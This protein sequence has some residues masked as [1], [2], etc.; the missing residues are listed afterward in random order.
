MEP[1]PQSRPGPEG[2]EGVVERY[3]NAVR[4]QSAAVP[5]SYP[6]P[7]S[8]R[9]PGSPRTPLPWPGPGAPPL[10][11]AGL[12]RLSALLLGY[13]PRRV[14]TLTSAGLS[15]LTGTPSSGPV[16][17][18]VLPAWFT[19]RRSVPSGGAY[20]PGEIYLAWTG[21]AELP[22]G[23]YHYDHV[24][25]CLELL[26]SASPVAELDRL[27]GA[28]GTPANGARRSALLLACRPWKNSGKYR[29]FGYQLGT[30]DVGVLLGQ[31]LT[32]TPAATVHLAPD[33]R[34]AD[35]LLGLDGVVESV[36]AV[37]ELPTTATVEPDAPPDRTPPPDPVGLTN[38]RLALAD[39]DPSAVALHRAI[40][41]G[42]D[43]AV[44]ADPHPPDTGAAASPP[45]P[46]TA[47]VR[48][49][50]VTSLDLAGAAAGRV[51][52]SDLAPG[53]RLGQL[54][55][56]LAYAGGHRATTTA[57]DTLSRHPLHP[58]LWCLVS[59]VDGL[60]PGAYR[61]DPRQHLLWPSAGTGPQAPTTNV[62]DR[63]MATAGVTVFVVAGGHQPMADLTPTAFR[64]LHLLTGAVVQLTALACQAVG[65]AARPI[66]GFSARDA[67]E[68]LGLPHG[69]TPVVQL[70]LG[71][72]KPRAGLLAVALTEGTSD[73]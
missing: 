39:A 71:A 6:P 50:E 69:H 16:F 33:P 5:A 51:S 3:L 23:V 73:A 38:D 36:Y 49:P 65:A 66:G 30:I 41:A 24:H 62:V 61:Y 12:D 35:D 29:A 42:G 53:L 10:T 28:T 25:H 26:R 72:P 56:I 59:Q 19:L 13:G 63:R 40:S 44:R 15:A 48:L 54:A 45:P 9:Y 18:R 8:K 20:Y 34:A 17:A 67:A 55:D 52:A 1:Q 21:S 57:L 14:E 64:Q 27:L 32:S 43:A 7:R 47:P 46:T 31:L 37:I 11:G 2:V 4:A 22:A 68:Q 58:S 70:L 60:P